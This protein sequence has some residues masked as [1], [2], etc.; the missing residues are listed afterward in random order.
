MKAIRRLKGDGAAI[1]SAVVVSEPTRVRTAPLTVALPLGADRDTAATI[2]ILIAEHRPI[3]RYGLRKLLDAERDFLVVGEAADG[4]RT[5]QLA[6]ELEPDVLLLDL[7]TL[8]PSGF[9]V[10]HELRRMGISVKTMLLVDGINKVESVQGLH[11]GARGILSKE[12]PTP[13]L[14]KSIRTVMAGGYWVGRETVSDLV[15]ALAQLPSSDDRPSGKWRLTPRELEMLALV[16]R[17]YTNKDIAQECALREDTVKH[18]LTN[19][20][21]K[22]GVSNRLELALFAIHH[23]LVHNPSNS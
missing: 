23:R 21:D 11:L 10:L 8:K 18:H 19:I 15:E 2:R 13:L 1:S 3:I 12:T 14:L 9:D 4:L 5:L 20:F 22:T 7:S 6:S 17:G 16:V